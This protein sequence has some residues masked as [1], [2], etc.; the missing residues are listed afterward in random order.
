VHLENG[1]FWNHEE[2]IPEIAEITLRDF[3]QKESP[4]RAENHLAR[5]DIS[6]KLARVTKPPVA[7]A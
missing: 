4:P 1:D 5:L 3:G 7:G 2:G 6:A